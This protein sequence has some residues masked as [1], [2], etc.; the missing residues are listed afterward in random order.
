M[1]PFSYDSRKNDKNWGK[2]DI[3]LQHQE[4]QLLKE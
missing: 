4:E 3:L 2:H 1:K